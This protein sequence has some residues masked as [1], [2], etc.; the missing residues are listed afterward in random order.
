MLAHLEIDLLVAQVVLDAQAE[1]ARGGD[2]LAGVVVGVVGDGGDDSLQRREPQRQVAAVVLD[3]NA[4]ETLERA[5]HRPMQHHRRDLVGMLV[6]IERAEAA[7]HV[8]VDLH[9]SA[10]PVAADGIAQRVFELRSIEGPFAL[11]ERPGPSRGLER[12][13]QRR[14]GLVPDRVVADA[15]L[16]PVRE[17]DAHIRE[18]EVLV[19]R[20][21][22]IV[23][24][25]AFFGDLV[26]G[27]EDVRII[28]RKGAHAHQAVQRAGRLVAMHLAELRELEGQVA[29]G[30]QAVLEDLDV[31]WAVHRLDHE[32]ALVVRAR[33]RQEHVLAEGRHVP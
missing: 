11:V 20:Q 26:L 1:R 22:E 31:A 12:G 29:V 27:D 10:L 17:L 6:D 14:L 15:L 3:E 32:A 18:A 5:E 33:L 24:L 19:D 13:P 4:D 30:L 7:R 2:H 23:H 9:G 16:R 25:E 8:E 28:L 21:D